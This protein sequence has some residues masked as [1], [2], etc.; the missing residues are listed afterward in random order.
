VSRIVGVWNRAEKFFVGIL[1]LAA[2]ACSFYGVVLRYVFR[3]TPDWIDEITIYMIIWSVFISASILAE[4]RG[5]VAATV[6]VERFPLRVRRTLAVFNGILALGFCGIISV[7][8]FWI[9]WQTYACNEKSPTSLH[10]PLWIAYLSVAVGCTLVGIR[11]VIRVYRLLFQFQ[12]SEILEGD[13]VIREEV[14]R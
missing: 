6:L 4:E 13:E 8:G 9:V 2:V 3:A 1:G 7:Y 14:L 12:R 10:F 11:Y 5:H